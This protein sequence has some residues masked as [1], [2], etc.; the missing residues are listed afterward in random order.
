M[1]VIEGVNVFLNVVSN[2]NKYARVFKLLVYLSAGARTVVLLRALRASNLSLL[3]LPFYLIAAAVYR[4]SIEFP[5]WSSRNFR[6]RK[7]RYKQLS[8][9]II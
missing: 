5:F 2:Y 4:V 1:T 8:K 3:R 9:Q 6:G 7:G